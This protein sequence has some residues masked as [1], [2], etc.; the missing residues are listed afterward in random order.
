MTNADR[1]QFIRGM[2]SVF[3]AFRVPRD[4]AVMEAYWLGVSSL[5]ID[6]FMRAVARAIA[7]CERMPPAAQLRKLAATGEAVVKTAD[8]I[9]NKYRCRLHQAHP[10]RVQTDYNGWCDVCRRHGDRDKARTAEQRA[11]IKA[12]VANSSWLKGI[13]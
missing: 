12:M 8:V 7:E 11:E 6:E 10:E 13:A 1:G 9:A 5:S 4:N 2:Y 3:D